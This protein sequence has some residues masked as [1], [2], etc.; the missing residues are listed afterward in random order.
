MVKRTYP[1]SEEDCSEMTPLSGNF[2]VA[3]KYAIPLNKGRSC[4]DKGGYRYLTSKRKM[5]DLRMFDMALEGG[6][7]Q[8]GLVF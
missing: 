6:F 8:M 1:L 3:I 2:R 4:V 5:S 7:L